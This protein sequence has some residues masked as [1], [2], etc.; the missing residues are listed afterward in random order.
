[1]RRTDEGKAVRFTRGGLT[2]VA[3]RGELRN[4]SN[5]SYS[6]VRVSGEKSAVVVVPPF[7]WEGLNNDKYRCL[8]EGI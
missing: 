8:V 3:Y 6:D 5:N 1:M 2:V 4:P 7:M